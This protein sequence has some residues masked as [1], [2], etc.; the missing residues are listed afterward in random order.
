M[1]VQHHMD[2]ADGWW[3]DHGKLFD[4]LILD[5]GCSPGPVL[6]LEPQ[7]GL[8]DLEG[9]LV[10]MPVGALGSV[11]HPPDTKFLVP[12]KNLVSGLA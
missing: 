11:L 3:L 6:L 9:Q 1:P 5:L 7:N 8:L 10:R 2:S 12:V 4:K